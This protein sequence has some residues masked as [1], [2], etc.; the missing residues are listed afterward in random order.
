MRIVKLVVKVD[1]ALDA[2]RDALTALLVELDQNI[3]HHDTDADAS[4]REAWA[5]MR[6][7]VVALRDVAYSDHYDKVMA[8]LART[9]AG[10]AR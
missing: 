6:T 2:Y 3:R 1:D 8:G 7:H 4:R 9:A 5:E 10:V